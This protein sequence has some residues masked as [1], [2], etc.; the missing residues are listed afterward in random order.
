MYKEAIT[1]LRTK[2]IVHLFGTKNKNQIHNTTFLDNS[3]LRY[4]IFSS[5]MILAAF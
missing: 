5:S 1:Y 2:E 3:L 4:S